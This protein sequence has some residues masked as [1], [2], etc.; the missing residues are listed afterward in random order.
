MKILTTKSTWFH[1]SDLRLDASFHLSEGRIA[2]IFIDKC[3]YEVDTL[4]NVTSKIFNGARFKRNYVEDKER[5]IPFMGSSDMLK[6]DLSSL[7]Y[8]SKKLS[9]NLEDL[10]LEKDWTLVSCS[11]TIGNTVYTNDDFVGK[12]AS[13]HVMRIIANSQ[14]IHSGYLHAFLSSKYGYN[15]L[16]QGTY[17][18]VIQHIEPHHIKDLPI[19]LLPEKQQEEIHQLIVDAAQLRV[20]ANRLLGQAVAY[21]EENIGKS[22][23]DLS[24]QYNK[25]SST[26]INSF[27]KRLDAQY[28]LLWKKLEKEKREDIVFENLG[29]FAKKIFVGNRGKR[30]YVEN[31]IPFLSSSEMMLFNPKKSCKTISPK[32]PA[33]KSLLVSKDEILISRSGTVGNTIIVNEDLENV[34]ISEHALR[35]VV[36]SSKISPQYVFCY[37]KTSH[38]MKSMEASSFGS[39]IITLNEDLIANIQLPILEE[40]SQNFIE[41]QIQK[42]QSKND[43]ATLKETQAIQLIENEI[44]TW[45]V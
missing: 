12:T 29:N 15:L 35:L 31:G 32:T 6:S 1:D 27:H 7:K 23:T 16:T 11:G 34:A 24:F 18:A 17:G 19:P 13:Q 44:S 37:L 36:D 45:Q 4:G 10:W 9:K 14:K 2:K 39:V 8:L 43:S 33:L 5:G 26:S 30:M 38:G 42:Y 28:Q 40:E 22:E 3:P 20:E 41:Q 25:I 21:F